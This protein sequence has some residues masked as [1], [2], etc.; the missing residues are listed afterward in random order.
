M[1]LVDIGTAKNASV[2]SKDPTG[3]KDNDNIIITGN[4]VNRTVTLTGTVEAYW[5]GKQVTALTSGW[6]SDPHGTDTAQRYY[7]SYDGSTFTWSTTPWTFDKLQIAVAFYDSVNASWRYVRETH[8][9]MPW[10]AHQE[11]HETIGTYKQSGGSITGFTLN[12]TTAANRRPDVATTYIKDED[13]ITINAALTS[14]LYTQ[15]YLSGASTNNFVLSQA[16]IV[17][18]SG[19]NPYYNQFTGGNWVQTLVS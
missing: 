8:G 3:F 6:T 16:D 18:L 12:S 17:P 11:L 7:L 15:F 19:N 5:Q 9:L 2:I 13:L 4:T 10:T 1:L 14:K